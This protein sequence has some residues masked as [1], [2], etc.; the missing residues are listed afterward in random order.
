L[1]CQ[2]IGL[3]IVLRAL[4]V[5]FATVKCWLKHSPTNMDNRDGDKSVLIAD[6]P[7]DVDQEDLELYLT[8]QRIGGGEITVIQLDVSNRTA[9][10]TFAASE[11]IDLS[12]L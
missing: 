10:V 11:G 8:N 4:S 5:E 1:Y 12:K 2:L 7:A 9:L 6:I 3:D